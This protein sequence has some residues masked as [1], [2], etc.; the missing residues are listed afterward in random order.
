MM[1][2]EQKAAKTERS[3]VRR[4]HRQE[5]MTIEERLLQN[6]RQRDRYNARQQNVENRNLPSLSTSITETNLFESRPTE[7]DIPQN[8]SATRRNMMTEEQRAAARERSRVSYRNRQENL[9]NEERLL[10]NARRQDQ[11]RDRKKSEENRNLA[12]SSTESLIPR[13]SPRFIGCGST[14]ESLIP[15]R[16]PR[17]IGYG[18]TT[19]SLDQSQSRD[20]QTTIANNSREIQLWRAQHK[21][22][23]EKMTEQQKRVFDERQRIAYQNRKTGINEASASSSV[24]VSKPAGVHRADSTLIPR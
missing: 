12:S 1:S 20:P 5:N 22:K 17:F 16:S 14:T 11:Y 4:R 6:E 8:H 9:T 23:Q 13:R 10:Q 24:E 19:E 2:E 21:S 7:M 18:S 3:R 15:R